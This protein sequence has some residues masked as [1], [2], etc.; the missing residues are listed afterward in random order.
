MRGPA[1]RSAPAPASAHASHPTA[2][3]T[4]LETPNYCYFL[5]GVLRALRPK[6]FGHVLC[7]LQPL[8]CGPS[9]SFENPKAPSLPVP[10]TAIH[11]PLPSTLHRRASGT[12]LTAA[13]P[14]V[15]TVAALQPT[16]ETNALPIHLAVLVE[17]DPH[18]AGWS[19]GPRP[20]APPPW[21]QHPA[22]PT[23]ALSPARTVPRREM[24]D[25]LSVST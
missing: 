17:L 18:T 2:G 9:F 15:G 22:P 24:R 12:Q 6:A 1:V 3:S 11:G 4:E 7:P 23:A 13:I 10:A 14:A 8:T 5:R 19:S 20:L 16:V 25:A 21:P